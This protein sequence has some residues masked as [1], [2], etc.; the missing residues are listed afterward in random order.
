MIMSLA[1]V[2]SLSFGIGKVIKYLSYEDGSREGVWVVVEGW[3]IDLE[4]FFLMI[5]NR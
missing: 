2:R 3:G 5:D 4:S 1:F